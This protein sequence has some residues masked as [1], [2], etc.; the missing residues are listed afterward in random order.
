MDGQN[1]KQREASVT[2]QQVQHDLFGGAVYNAKKNRQTKL[3]RTDNL[4]QIPHLTHLKNYMQSR[5]TELI[6]TYIGQPVFCQC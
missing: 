2:V 1:P 6:N 5:M 3:C 4:R